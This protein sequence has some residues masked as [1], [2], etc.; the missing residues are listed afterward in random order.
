[1]QILP[2][3]SN[4]VPLRSSALERPSHVRGVERVTELLSQT[5]ARSG[6]ERVLQG[7]FLERGQESESVEPRRPEIFE[8]RKEDH[9][10]FYRR[11]SN[12]DYVQREALAA[13]QKYANPNTDSGYGRGVDYFV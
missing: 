13:Y 5:S 11:H 8:G 3:A 2:I 9:P 12:R 1:M 7:E 4:L 10:A 6:S